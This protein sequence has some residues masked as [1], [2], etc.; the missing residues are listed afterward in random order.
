MTLASDIITSIRNSL[1]DTDKDRWSD[2]RLLE[3]LT[4]GLHDIAKNTSLFVE[5]KFYVVANLAVDIDFT[6][7]S[8][9][10]LR[11]EYLDKN[12]PFYT[13][14]EMDSKNKEWQFEK[15]DKVK[16]IVYNK[17]QRGLYKLYPIVENTQNYHIE[18]NQLFGI[19]TDISYS[20]I[21][22]VMTDSIGDIAHIPDSALIKFYY[23]RKH[24][25]VT[26]LS[27]ELK[28]DELTKVLLKHYIAGHALRDNHDAQNRQFAAEELQLYYNK[29]KDYA[30]EKSH[31]F[32]RNTVTAR[33]RPND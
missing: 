8:V 14:Q 11:A 29:T 9:K 21:Q 18:Y 15:G 30:I 19:T 31:G 25:N 3:L 17:Q 4:D 20:D 5:V 12:L 10:I 28:I 23:I 26:A 22:P 13:F 2:T 33:Y 6:D 24:A 27:D 32:V 7:S 16:A 1:A